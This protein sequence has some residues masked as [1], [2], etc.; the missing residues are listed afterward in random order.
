MDKKKL[1]TRDIVLIAFLAILLFVQEEVL[2]FLPNIQLTV[3]LLVLYSKKLGMKRTSFIILIHVLFDNLLMGSFNLYYVPFMFLGWLLIPTL[4][5]TLFKRMNDSFSL[6]MLGILF[7]FLYSWIYLIPGIFLYQIDPVVYLMSD[8]LLE[9]LL[10]ISSF[11]SI[12]WL[13]D[14]C[15][16][17]FD[18]YLPSVE[19]K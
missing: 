11:L 14:P 17:I 15:A 5:Q 9:L 7:S 18:R 16:N 8:I 10:A 1:S 6:A 4:L 12:L 3:F 19:T 13:Y 2:T